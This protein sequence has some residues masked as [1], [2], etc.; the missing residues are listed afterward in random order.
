MT[1]E[2]IT[3]ET[4][5]TKHK[6]RRVSCNIPTR[7]VYYVCTSRQVGCNPAKNIRAAT[8][9]ECLNLRTAEESRHVWGKPVKHSPRGPSPNYSKV[10]KV[11]VEF[12]N[13]FHMIE[14]MREMKWEQEIT[15]GWR[16]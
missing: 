8:R 16:D 9:V 1:E 3:K 4:Q 10:T 14:A 2:K 7:L 5:V 11:D 12:D 15:T 6:A 13:V